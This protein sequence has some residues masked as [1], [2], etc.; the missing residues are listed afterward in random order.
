MGASEGERLPPWTRWTRCLL[1]SPP[2]NT[3]FSLLVTRAGV[4]PP[5]GKPDT[6]RAALRHPTLS[7][8]PQ[9]GPSWGA[10]LGLLGRL[11]PPAPP[12]LR[13]LGE[14]T[15][16]V[17]SWLPSREEPRFCSV[18]GV[19]P[20]SVGSGLCQARGWALTVPSPGAAEQ[21]GSPPSPAPMGVGALGWGQP[22]ASLPPRPPGELRLLLALGVS[23]LG[24]QV[25]PGFAGGWATVL[26]ACPGPLRRRL[27]GRDT[28]AARPGEMCSDLHFHSNF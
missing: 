3:Q 20:V 25:C 11:R 7:A 6:R 15:A 21:A 4:A 10:V 8:A 27:T 19:E 22:H 2:R 14:G 26:P 1:C 24:T 23:G 9:E 13:L 28:A 5:P 18:K 17:P 12:Q 16:G